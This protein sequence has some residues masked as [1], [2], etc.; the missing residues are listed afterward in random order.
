MKFYNLVLS[1]IFSL[2]VF[3]PTCSFGKDCK[4]LSYF[5][6]DFEYLEDFNGDMDKTCTAAEKSATWKACVACAGDDQRNQQCHFIQAKS[7][8][9]ENKI[10]CSAYAEAVSEYCKDGPI[11]EKPLVHCGKITQPSPSQNPH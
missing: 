11:N 2:V 3:L 8:P 4:P 5:S 7:L 1:S 9:H 10:I 6:E